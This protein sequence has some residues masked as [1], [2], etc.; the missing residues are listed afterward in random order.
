MNECNDSLGTAKVLSTLVDNSSYWHNE[1][2]QTDINKTGIVTH[3]GLYLYT[4]MLFRLRNAPATSQRATDITL[5]PVKWQHALVYLNDVFI[6][7]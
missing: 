5:F 6:F 3:N 2:D 1:L 7:S 4:I